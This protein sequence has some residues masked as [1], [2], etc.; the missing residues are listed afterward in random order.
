MNEN[1]KKEVGDIENPAEKEVGIEIL[2]LE[3]NLNGLRQDIEDMGGED[4]LQ[5]E[6]DKNELLSTRWSDR[7]KRTMY[8][9]NSIIL[10]LST[11]TFAAVDA[12]ALPKINWDIP[13]DKTLGLCLTAA[14][15]VGVLSSIASIK[16]FIKHQKRATA[17]NKILSY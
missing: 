2:K 16:E 5:E 3:E 6:L 8:L 13:D 14:T 9:I 10:T 15:V 11:G 12:S 7:Y 4:K 1:L 17:A